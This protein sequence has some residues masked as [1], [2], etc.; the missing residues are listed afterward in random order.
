MEFDLI[1]KD[2]FYILLTT[3]A[4]PLSDLATK[5][6]DLVVSYRLES[7]HLRLGPKRVSSLNRF[8]HSLTFWKRIAC[9]QT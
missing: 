6:G 8:E 3:V 7:C 5:C 2:T 1:R 4:P 9:K